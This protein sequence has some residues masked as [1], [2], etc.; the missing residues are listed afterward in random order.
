MKLN[1][2]LCEHKI[3]FIVDDQQY[4]FVFEQLTEG[5]TKI[6]F[7]SDGVASTNSLLSLVGKTA[8]RLVSNPL[9]V[10][11]A[12]T[13]LASAVGKWKAQQK[14]D[15]CFSSITSTERKFYEKMVKDLVG[16]GK[17]HILKASQLPGSNYEWI[18]RKG[19]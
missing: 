19:K 18:L 9:L 15:I 1:D 6:K 8:K 13:T 3:V 4:A 12:G 16:T 10:A 14:S 7:G 11:I 5:L 2:L 17:Y